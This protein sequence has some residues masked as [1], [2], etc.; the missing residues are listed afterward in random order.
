MCAVHVGNRR[1]TRTHIPSAGQVVGEE[2]REL[3]SP[4]DKQLA[5]LPTMG[6]VALIESQ[7]TETTGH[8]TG[9]L[10]MYM[11]MTGIVNIIF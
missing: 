5:P 4:H 6:L 3:A 1:S 9:A 7:L 11:Y 8:Y 10:Y 2:G